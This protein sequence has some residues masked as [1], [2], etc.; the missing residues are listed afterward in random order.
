MSR[1]DVDF[2]YNRRLA[3]RT[4][5]AAL[6]AGTAT[7]TQKDQ[8]LKDCVELLI[9]DPQFPA[10]DR[11]YSRA[12]NTDGYP[13]APEYRHEFYVANDAGYRSA[14]AYDHSEDFRVEAAAE[15]NLMELVLQGR[16]EHTYREADP[17][18]V[19]RSLLRNGFRDKR[20]G[21]TD[22][23]R[24]MGAQAPQ[25]TTILSSIPTSGNVPDLS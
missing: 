24:V 25:S 22:P 3:M 1:Y 4:A 14:W 16:A 7:Q 2:D 12:L 18:I 15:P 8:L 9:D 13:N 11:E 23:P 17:E 20:E 19:D 10:G 5:R 21:E 6:L